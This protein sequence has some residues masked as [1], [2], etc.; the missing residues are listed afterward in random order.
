[1]KVGIVY[2]SVFKLTKNH[3]GIPD[4]NHCHIDR[5]GR[6]VCLNSDWSSPSH[7]I[8]LLGSHADSVISREVDKDTCTLPPIDDVI[9][10]CA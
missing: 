6:Q 10:R 5:S 1:M 7:L 9:N 8:R 3:I 4:T 2:W